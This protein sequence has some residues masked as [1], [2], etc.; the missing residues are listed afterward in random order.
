MTKLRF[1]LITALFISAV[2]FS[3]SALAEKVLFFTPSRVLL[4][5]QDRVEVVNVTNLSSIARAYSISVKDLVMTEEGVTQEVDSFDYSARRLVRFVPR[6]FVL[7]PGERQTIRVMTRLSKK[8]PEGEY[9]SHM[10][11]LENVQKRDEINPEMREE[12]ASMQA[13]LAYSTLIP[14]VISHGNI[15]TQ[16]GADSAKIVEGRNGTKGVELYLTRSGNGQGTAYI[17]TE[18][19]FADGTTETAAPRST[20][21]IYRELSG[22]KKIVQLQLSEQKPVSVNVKIYD[23][24]DEDAVPVKT[25]DL[26]M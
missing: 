14:I 17:D 8:L 5:S 15:D 1:F 9:H 11:F 24:T 4:N 13:P 18:Y 22:R 26:D 23:S 21:Y 25:F 12:G 16:V 10:Q 6:Q 7:Q 19:S 3:A 20:A 2:G